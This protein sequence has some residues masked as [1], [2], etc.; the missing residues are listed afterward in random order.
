MKHLSIE[1]YLT[2]NRFAEIKVG[3]SGADVY[4][5]NGD[6]ILKHVERRKLESSLFDTYSREALFYQSRADSGCSYLPK[7]IGLEISDDEIILLMKKYQCPHRGDMDEPMIRKVARALACVHTDS[8]PEFLDCDRK[9]VK[10]LSEPQIEEYL[11]GWKDVLNEHPGAFDEIP[12]KETAE[13]INRIIAWHNT[14]ESVLV[15]GDFHWEN[16]LTDDCGNILICDWQSVGV[17][18]ASGD[19]SFFMSR[20]GSDGVRLDPK[21]FLKHYADAI[22]EISGRT[23]D[24]QSIEEH[25][26][27]A[28]VITSFAF[29]HQFLHGAAV[30]RVRGIYEKMIDDCMMMNGSPEAVKALNDT[31]YGDCI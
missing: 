6:S 27:A 30:E 22:R 15:H 20:L 18:G 7:I 12:L 19:I 10:I 4:E 29:W 11:A 24:I 26:A 5:I 3:Q 13:K 28:N 23:V 2:G 8:I 21:I 9:P 25:M 14:E 1:N 31:A 16:L 17:G